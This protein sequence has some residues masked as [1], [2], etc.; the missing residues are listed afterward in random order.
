MA[1]HQERCTKLSRD[2]DISSPDHT[3]SQTA[4]Q[5][6]A[7]DNNFCQTTS[8]HIIISV[9]EYAEHM[10]MS[11]RT[12]PHVTT[13]F[14][15]DM[16]KVVSHR[17]IHKDTFARDGAKLTYTAYFVAATAQA[18]SAFPKVYSSWSEEGLILHRNINIG[19]AT[20]LGDKG[21]IVPVIKKQMNFTTRDCSES[22]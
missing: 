6:S 17:T 16:S 22:K 9:V 21:L 20:S 10:V 13:V 18:L 7:K 19:M 14:E 3:R 4:R 5:Q 8:S 15:A 1:D 2:R 12:S 11:K